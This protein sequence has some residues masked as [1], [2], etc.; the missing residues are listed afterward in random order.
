[1]HSIALTRPDRQS[2]AQLVAEE[3]VVE[4]TA[5]ETLILQAVDPAGAAEVPTNNR[6]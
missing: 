2:L 3:G 6:F 1:M 4:E 5:E